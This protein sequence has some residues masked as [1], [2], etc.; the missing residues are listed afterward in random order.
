MLLSISLLE[1]RIKMTNRI[2]PTRSRT[3]RDDYSRLVMRIT[4]RFRLEVNEIIKM[5]VSQPEIVVFADNRSFGSTRVL[6]SMRTNITNE[7]ALLLGQVIRFQAQQGVNLAL[8]Q[9]TSKTRRGV[10]GQFIN[11]KEMFVVP[12]TN[13]YEKIPSDRHFTYFI[14]L[15]E[16]RK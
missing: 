2:D 16:I 3:R 10:T 11:K 1:K 13:S 8:R 15:K 5:I 14:I 4:R 7:E 12:M 6:Q 9:V